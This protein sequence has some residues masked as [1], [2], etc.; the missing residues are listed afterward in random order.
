MNAVFYFAYGSNM[1]EAR[2]EERKVKPLKSEKAKLRG[3]KLIF[4]KA[5]LKPLKSN[6]GYASIVKSGKEVVEGVLYTLTKSDLD[7]LDAR[8]GY[9]EHY[10]RIFLLVEKENRTKMLAETYVAQPRWIRNGLKP[11]KDYV[12][13]LAEGAKQHE[14]SE[15]YIKKL[16][17]VECLD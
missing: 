1:D 14:L 17:S 15:G 8:E 4:N 9:P 5:P 13:H 10:D 2:M 11:S 7:K 6:E 16:Q 12:L 3:Y